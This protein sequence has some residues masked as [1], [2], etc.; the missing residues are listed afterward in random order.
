ML[1]AGRVDALLEEQG[2]LEAWSERTDMDMTGSAALSYQNIK[3]IAEYAS[4]FGASKPS[5]QRALKSGS[6]RSS[7]TNQ[8]L[9]EVG[10]SAIRTTTKLL[11]EYR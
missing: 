10:T 4:T 5:A 6:P 9:E 3:V 11:G 2:A 1:N 8:S 7:I